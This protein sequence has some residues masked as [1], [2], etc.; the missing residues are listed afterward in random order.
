MYNTPVFGHWAPIKMFL[1]GGG[2]GQTRFFFNF[3]QQ[4]VV[5]TIGMPCCFD[6]VFQVPGG[7]TCLPLAPLCSGRLVFVRSINIDRVCSVMS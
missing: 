1:W 3:T 7:W 2:G 4:I 5:S 6:R